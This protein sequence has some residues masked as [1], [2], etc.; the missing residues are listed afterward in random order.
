[1]RRVE[2]L[3]RFSRKKSFPILSR[4]RPAAQGCWDSATFPWWRRNQFRQ[5]AAVYFLSEDDVPPINQLEVSQIVPETM[6]P[7]RSGAMVLPEVTLLLNTL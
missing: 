1:M 7:S 4:L 5:P 2:L 6:L 3:R